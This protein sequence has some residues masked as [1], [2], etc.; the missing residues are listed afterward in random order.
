MYALP[1]GYLKQEMI[2]FF[3]FYFKALHSD[4]SITL[5]IYN[6]GL[7]FVFIQMIYMTLFCKCFSFTV[8]E[9][10]N[11]TNS[12]NFSCIYNIE[13]TFYIFHR[14]LHPQRFSFYIHSINSNLM[15]YSEIFVWEKVSDRV[16]SKLLAMRKNFTACIR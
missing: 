3:V 9:A 5:L 15:F 16:S 13:I 14:Y 10:K 11:V 4:K 7:I 6:N 1:W 2:P 12:N 8:Y